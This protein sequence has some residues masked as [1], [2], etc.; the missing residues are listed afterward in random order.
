MTAEPIF[1][2][3]SSRKGMSSHLLRQVLNDEMHARLPLPAQAPCMVSALIFPIRSGGEEVRIHAALAALAKQWQLPEPALEFVQYNATYGSL[4][5]SCS[6]HTEFFRLTLS[7]NQAYSDFSATPLEVLPLDWLSSL[8]GNILV[9][10][11]L[12]LLPKLS[13]TPQEISEYFFEGHQLIGAEIGKGNGLAFTDLR[14]H[15]DLHIQEGASRFVVIN[16]GLMGANQSGRMIQR[17]IEIEAYRMLALLAL[18]IAKEQMRTLDSLGEQLRLLIA[19]VGQTEENDAELMDALSALSIKAENM[20]GGSE[21]RFAA[22]Q[23]YHLVVER[24]VSELRENRLLGLG[25]QPFREFIDRRLEPAMETC[26]IVTRRQD[27]FMKRLQRASTLL[28]TRIE[29]THER[30]NQALLSSVNQRAA[31]QLRMQ[32]TVESLSVVVLTYYL[33]ALCAYVIKGVKYFFPAINVELF[34]ASLVIP[35]ALFIWWSKEQLMHRFRQ[36]SAVKSTTPLDD[37]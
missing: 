14:L 36:A 17:L 37:L 1:Q 31:L 9:A 33:I 21:Y 26:R 16:Q 32:E 7:S 10:V 8:P 5:M 19:R 23:A 22:S 28:R 6:R 24:R 11:H 34:N 12:L 4:T 13:S 20:V 29:V 2:D 18:P 15:P 25:I 35:V 3:S 27:R 30:Q